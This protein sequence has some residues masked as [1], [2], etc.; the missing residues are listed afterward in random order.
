MEHDGSL[1]ISIG[2]Q[3]ELVR[4][5]AGVLIVH[6]NPDPDGFDEWTVGEQTFYVKTDP[7]Q[8]EERAALVADSHFGPPDDLHVI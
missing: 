1:E 4:Q 3:L 7:L 8:I 6:V 2:A 5:I